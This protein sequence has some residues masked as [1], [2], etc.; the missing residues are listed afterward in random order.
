MATILALIISFIYPG[1]QILALTILTI[2]LPLIY[3]IGH[4]YSK[5]AIRDQNDR[6]SS[7]VKELGLKKDRYIQELEEENSD[8]ID[9]IDSAKIEK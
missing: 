3:Q 2:L 7:I 9:Y 8:L 5:E 4:V 6:D 1:I